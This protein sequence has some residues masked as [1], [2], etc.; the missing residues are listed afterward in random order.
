MRA[1]ASPRLIV[2]NPL[3]MSVDA[4]NPFG[5]AFSLKSA[6][7]E[8]AEMDLE[9]LR[10]LVSV[11][12]GLPLVEAFAGTLPRRV[13]VAVLDT[14]FAAFFAAFF[15]MLPSAP[16]TSVSGLALRPGLLFPSIPPESLSETWLTTKSSS[17]ILFRKAPECV[18]SHSQI[19]SG[20]QPIPVRAFTARR[21]LLTFA[22]SFS[23]HHAC[24]VTGIEDR[25]HPS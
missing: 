16:H 23:A 9:A 6:A 24:R 4:L 21:S 25:R 3:V 20:F 13:F 14:F 22:S 18:V 10:P 12:F 8:T 17:A 7:A 11:F 19:T 2:T 15:A 5:S 1:S